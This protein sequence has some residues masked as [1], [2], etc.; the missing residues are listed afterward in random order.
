LHMLDSLQ[1]CILGQVEGSAGAL[2]KM[3]AVAVGQF[4]FFI[5]HRDTLQLFASFSS[6]ALARLHKRLMAT[7]MEKW[8]GHV[9]HVAELV[10]EGQRTGALRRDIEPRDIALSFLGMTNQ[11]AQAL[12]RIGPAAKP[13]ASASAKRGVFAG[14]KSGVFAGAK[15]GVFASGLR[16]AEPH[17]S[18]ERMA[19]T[20][21]RILMEGVRSR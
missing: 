4:D 19:D 13:G 11:A 14:A 15:S 3:R 9:Q 2:A 8:T 16:A 12:V 1:A 5:R 21:M 20:I 18:P 7:M 17:E 10:E 6:P